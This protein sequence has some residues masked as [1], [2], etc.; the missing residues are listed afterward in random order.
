MKIQ[1]RA[2]LGNL[3]ALI[4]AVLFVTLVSV[5]IGCASATIT[6]CHS[7]CDYASIQ[8]AVD[9]AD[10]GDIIEVH[11]GTYYEHVDVNKALILKGVD[12]GSGKPVVDA[13]G[14]NS[15]I[16]LS[17]DRITL[18]EFTATNAGDG[19]SFRHYAGILVTSNNN[20]ITNN[21]ASSNNDTGILLRSSS[22]NT[23]TGNTVSNNSIGIGLDDSCNN[24]ITR[25]TFLNDGLSVDGSYQ[26]TIKGNTVNG[27]PLVY[28]EDKAGI[29]VTDAGQVILVNCTNITVENL[30]L[31]NTYVAVSLL[32]TEESVISNNTVSN[33]W[34]GITLDDSCNNTIIGNNASNN[35]WYGITLDDSCNNNTITGNN[36]SN[37]GCGICIY[38][39]SNNTFTNNTVCSNNDKGICIISTCNNTFTN[40]TISNNDK[41]IYLI[42]SGCNNNIIC[43]TFL[44][45][46]LFVGFS[47]QNTVKGNTVN[48]NTVNGKPLVYL[49]DTSDTEV[50]D[51]GQVILVNCSNITVENLDLS[52]TCVGIEL[53]KT[54][55]SIISNN[56]IS[57]NNM[58]GIHLMDSSNNTLTGNNVSNN[59][60]V[61]IG[62]WGGSNNNK[63]YL[64]NFINNTLSVSSTSNIWNSTEQ[65][66]YT[67]NGS[68]YTNYLGNYWSDYKE[69]Y[70]DAEEID[71]T[72]IW[73]MPYR[74]YP[75]NDFYPLMV[76]FEAYVTTQTKRT[77]HNI[78]TGKNYS[79]IQGAIDDPMTFAGHTITV[80]AGTYNE[81]VVVNKALTLRGI[82]MPVVDAGGNDSAITLSV[83][84]ITLEGFNAT[85]SGSQNGDAGIKIISSNNTLTDNTIRNTNNGM[86]LYFS[87]G[88]N[89]TG[90]TVTNSNDGIGLSSSCNNIIEGNTVTKNAGGI[91]LSSSHNNNIT[92]NNITNSRWG[93]DFYNSNNNTISN[94]TVNNN[95]N[96]M[97]LYS[98]GDNNIAGNTVR[99]NN[100]GINLTA[101]CNGNTIS[102]NYVDKND[103][104]IYISYSRNN[105][106]TSNDI[107][108][109]KYHGICL[110]SS[111]NN[112]NIT[113]NYVYNNSDDGIHIYSS[114]NNEIYLNDF[115]NNTDN[116]Y[117]SGSPNIW[118]SQERFTYTYNDRVRKNYLGNYWSDYKEKYPDAGEIAGSGLWNIPY[119]IEE[120]KDTYPLMKPVVNYYVTTT[121]T[122]DTGPS[123][124]A[125]PASF[126][127]H[128]GTIKPTKILQ[129]IKLYT[130]PCTGTGGHTEYAKICKGSR[131]IETEPW[132]G[133]KGDWHNISFSKPFELL[134]NVEYNYTIKTGSYPQIHH[135]NAL[136]T[137]DGWIN[138]TEF[139][140]ANG[141]IQYDWLPAIKLL[142]D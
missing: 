25:N 129:V 29:E 30:E 62:L 23:I 48:G 104:A 116:V 75:D 119:S 80:D 112:N 10:S 118:Y 106:I 28:L 108:N 126:G 86:Y 111:S 63:F 59:G 90:N 33:N 130:Y 113:N 69:K 2:E 13:G 87:R 101:S 81:N 22:N 53:C 41:G 58:Y 98:S 128:N 94:N 96:G 123:K 77:V 103:N 1:K 76:H 89:V 26:N 78:D 68:S 35:N 91:D 137:A 136:L 124:K 36:A 39:S 50:T 16:T 97:Y 45:D 3:R 127:I 55:D 56:T 74:I 100:Y 52:S 92:G 114:S 44:N 6:V 46:G 12:T 15:A 5:G 42:N 32:I 18:E 71:G 19:Y 88:N 24:N 38:K 7:G 125:Y 141:D 70:P 20:T 43:N 105:T 83:D 102:C 95:N 138:C 132:D 17:V 60:E 140:D 4:F 14:N 67:Y 82:G 134:P 51:A 109:S 135:T 117:S 61:D 47:Y 79:T 66:T 65:I 120:D 11:S 142:S 110:T 99:D 93:C 85:N 133:Y 27:K 139:K 107:T 84:G 131:C 8:A 72:G 40:N 37:N 21:T 49:E 115:I 34:C 121:G 9:A 54:N 57:N 73:D 122:F 64:N 31:S